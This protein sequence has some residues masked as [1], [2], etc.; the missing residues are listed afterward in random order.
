MWP[1]E[2]G[3]RRTAD[4]VKREAG[5]PAKAKKW[6]VNAASN[7]SKTLYKFRLPFKLIGGT[8]GGGFLQWEVVSDGTA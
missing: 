1:P 3:K 4:D 6:P 7:A 2:Q 5:A 8:T